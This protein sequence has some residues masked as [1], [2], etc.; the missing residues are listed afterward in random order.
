MGFSWWGSGEAVD[1]ETLI[2]CSRSCFIV[3]VESFFFL[4]VFPSYPFRSPQLHLLRFGVKFE[5]K[6]GNKKH[7]KHP[8][9]LVYL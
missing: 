2:D 5:E 9:L 1:N 6:S 3:R 4:D 7:L 8:Y